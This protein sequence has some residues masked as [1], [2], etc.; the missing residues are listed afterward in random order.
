MV[1]VLSGHAQQSAAC[2]S[3]QHSSEYPVHSTSAIL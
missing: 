1:S 2:L 3:G